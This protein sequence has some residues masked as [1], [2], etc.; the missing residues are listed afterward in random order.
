[1]K[2]YTR[3]E[4]RQLLDVEESFLFSLEQEEI[5]WLDA[6]GGAIVTEVGRS[7]ANV[8]LFGA[9]FDR[10]LRALYAP[11]WKLIEATPGTP[12][13]F[14]IARDPGELTNVVTRSA[15]VAR[16]LAERFDE[17][18]RLHPPLFDANERAVL[19]ADTEEALRALGY[20]E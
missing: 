13:L 12:Q 3:A 14:D 20:L 5:I 17:I 2:Y 15:D 16:G 1:M 10:D 18:A 19:D 7:D 11:P 8:R 6:P 4:L 9:F